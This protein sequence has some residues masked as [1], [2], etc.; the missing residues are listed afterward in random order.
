MKQR[1]F[2]IVELLI[3]IIIIAILSVIALPQFLNAQDR[4]KQSQTVAN[5]RNIANA[6]ALYHADENEY[7]NV[8]T[9]GAL[10]TILEDIYMEVMPTTD[11]WG[12]EFFISAASTEYTLG[13]CGKSTTSCSA[14][15]LKDGIGGVINTFTDDIIVKN[16]SFIQYPAGVQQ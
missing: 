4:G 10:K 1:G 13:S 11:G 2:T 3:V 6:L 8:S 16:G 5:L 7:P 15:T 9:I 12:N 14:L